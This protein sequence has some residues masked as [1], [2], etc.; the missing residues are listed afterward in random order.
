MQD[1]AQIPPL[2]DRL[3]HQYFG[4]V[5]YVVFS[6]LEIENVEIGLSAYIFKKSGVVR[7]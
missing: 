4:I 6:M 2:D 3:L 7:Q 5:M 1:P